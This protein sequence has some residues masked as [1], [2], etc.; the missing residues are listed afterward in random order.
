MIF[1]EVCFFCKHIKRNFPRQVFFNIPDGTK[2]I[3]RFISCHSFYSFQVFEAL[4]SNKG[5]PLFFRGSFN[6]Q[7]V[8]Y[9]VLQVK[10]IYRLFHELSCTC[11]ECVHCGITRPVIGKEDNRYI[12]IKGL[13][14]FQQ[15][16]SP[17][18]IIAA[19][20]EY[21]ISLTLFYEIVGLSQITRLHPLPFQTKGTI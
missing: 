14:F 3:C 15:S 2:D 9:Y 16:Q 8:F 4:R 19:V 6:R 18:N 10:N 21:K 13:D 12:R 5:Y 7:K 20:K 11:T 1:A 17:C